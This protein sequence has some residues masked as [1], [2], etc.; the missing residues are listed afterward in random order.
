[1]LIVA[2]SAATFHPT[3][4]HTK[5]GGSSRVQNAATIEK[6]PYQEMAAAILDVVKDY[7]DP[8]CVIMSSTAIKTRTTI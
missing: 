3:D 4:A 6:D 1:M 8:G 2:A 5:L 7:P